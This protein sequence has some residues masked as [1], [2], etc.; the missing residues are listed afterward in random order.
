ML[1]LIQ[2]LATRQS[3]NFVKA[4]VDDKGVNGHRQQR[5]QQDHLGVHLGQERSTG[6][7]GHV[8]L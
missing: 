7:T 8:D 5:R 2:R 4:F 3:F 6:A 1:E